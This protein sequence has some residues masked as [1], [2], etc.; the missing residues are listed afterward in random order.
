[1]ALLLYNHATQLLDQLI[2][3]PMAELPFENGTIVPVTPD[4]ASGARELIQDVLK[5]KGTTARG[6][7]GSLQY[8]IVTLD[9]SQDRYTIMLPG[10]SFDVDY[11]DQESLRF[12]GREQLVS[13]ERVQAALLEIAERVNVLAA[14]GTEDQ[15]VRGFYTNASVSLDSTADDLSTMDGQTLKSWFVGKK[16]TAKSAARGRYPF[17]HVSVPDRV[18][19]LMQEKYINNTGI[20]VAESLTQST[21]GYPPVFDQVLVADEGRADRLLEAGINTSGKERIVF[22]SRDEMYVEMHVSAPTMLGQEW[23]ET[24]DGKMIFPVYQAVSPVIVK[25]TGSMAY[26]DAT[27]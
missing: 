2:T 8:P 25:H 21:G 11:H 24:K 7:T 23:V 18:L 6:S 22:Y 20:T 27:Y 19:S 15:T 9:M 26:V 1:M 10:A 12:S 16:M 14:Y 5:R 13:R 3:E 17:R 4:I